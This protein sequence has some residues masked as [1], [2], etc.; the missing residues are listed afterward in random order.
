MPSQL[1]LMTNADFLLTHGKQVAPDIKGQ[2]YTQ[3]AKA[4]MEV[5]TSMTFFLMDNL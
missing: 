1:P 4:N 5:L 2:Y 3:K